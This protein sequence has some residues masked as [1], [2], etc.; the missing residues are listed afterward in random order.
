[1]K[2]KSI[3]VVDDDSIFKIII[4]KLIAKSDKFDNVNLFSNGEEASLALK[5]CIKN[6]EELPDIILLD[7]E[8]PIMNGWEFMNEINVLLSEIV[9]KTIKI[10]ISSSSITFEDKLKADAHPNISGYLT[11]PITLEDLYKI[12]L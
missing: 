6:K 7:I 11:K 2:K 1:M 8:M 3:W 12:V 4:Q 10:F 5:E 9:D